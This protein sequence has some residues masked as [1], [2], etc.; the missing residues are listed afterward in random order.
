MSKGTVLIVEDNKDLVQLLEYNLAQKQYI[1]VAALD[2]LTACR[3]IEEE[4]PDLILLDLMLPDL[5]GWEICRMVRSHKHEEISETPIIMLTALDSPGDKLKGLELGADDY[6]PK[7]FAI[8]EVL[9]KVS[10]QI[11]KN[12]NSQQLNTKI[13]K[14]E[15]RQNKHKEFQDILFH[16]LRNQLLVIRGFSSR[17]LKKHGL[18]PGKYRS[19]AGV[20]E[21]SSGFLYSM[22]E[23]I[24]LLSKLEIGEYP[25]PLE[26]ICMEET[27]RQIISIFIRPAKEEKISIRFEK[28]GEFSKIRLNLAGLKIC[29]SNLIENAIKYSPPKTCVTVNLLCRKEKTVVLKIKDSG[30]GIPED[31]MESIFK[32]FYRGR[33]VKDNIKGTGLGLYIAKTLVERMGGTI[34]VLNGDRVGCCFEIT[35]PTH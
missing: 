21:K 5:N 28:A 23:D 18:A 14:L 6:I 26:E 4:K 32:K 29:L 2:G 13:R 9:L 12:R 16:E 1:P 19:Y 7:P 15:W 17:I 11:R 22:A 27:V 8:K 10:R 34:R 33:N 20:I 30:P 35:Y 3:M 24:I 31:E 25:L